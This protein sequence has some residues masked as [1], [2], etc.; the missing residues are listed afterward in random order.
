M[1]KNDKNMGKNRGFHNSLIT[2]ALQKTTKI[3]PKLFGLLVVFSY[4]Y[5]YQTNK[6]YGLPS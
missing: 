6:R 5:I 2:N 3:V 4:L 1:A